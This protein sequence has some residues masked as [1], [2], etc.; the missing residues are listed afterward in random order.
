MSPRAWDGRRRVGGGVL[1]RDLF[2]LIR[3]G[4]RLDGWLHTWVFFEGVGERIG[5]IPVSWTLSFPCSLHD[6]TGAFCIA[7]HY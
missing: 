6:Y 7:L 1:R 4:R 2:P 3:L 5:L